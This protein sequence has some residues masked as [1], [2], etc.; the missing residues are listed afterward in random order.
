VLG[1]KELQILGKRNGIFGYFY[2]EMKIPG[3]QMA[4]VTMNV[5]S[6]SALLFD[7][8]LN[9]NSPPSAKISILDISFGSCY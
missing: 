6:Q 7:I 4:T 3:H 8:P 2:L 5:E 1:L 9:C